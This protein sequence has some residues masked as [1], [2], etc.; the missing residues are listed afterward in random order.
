[1]TP[2]D[3]TTLEVQALRL[4]DGLAGFRE[5]D[6]WVYLRLTDSDPATLAKREEARAVLQDL[7]ARNR[8]RVVAGR[9]WRVRGAE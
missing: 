3:A 7:V 2:G 8:L 9:F 5:S 4:S 1:M 6:L